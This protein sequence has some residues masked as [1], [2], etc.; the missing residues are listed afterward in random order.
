MIK[1]AEPLSIAE[2]KEF[3][4]GK[5]EHE[6]GIKNFLDKFSKISGEDAKKIRE[7][8]EELDLIK[9]KPEDISKII[10]ILPE[11]EG[12]L[13]K[14]FVGVNLEEDETKKILEIVKEFK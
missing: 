6:E 3:I 10:D 4:S 12:E 8:I 2:A 9:I 1:N 7:K 14:I 5:S 11:N 13:G